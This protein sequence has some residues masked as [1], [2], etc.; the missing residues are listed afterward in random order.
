MGAHMTRQVHG[1]EGRQLQKAGIDPAMRSGVAARHS[2]DQVPLEPL[3][4]MFV[5]Q[6]IDLGGIDGGIH[7][8]RHQD[9][10][11]GRG[12]MVVFGHQRRSRQHGRA[13]LAYRHA[14]RARTDMPEKRD[15]VI[16]ILVGAEAAFGQRHVAAA[17]P[18]GDIDVVIGQQGLGGAPQQGGEMPRHRGRQQHSRLARSALLAKMY[19]VAERHFQGDLLGDG[20]AFALHRHLFDAVRRPVMDQV[21]AGDDLRPGRNAAKHVIGGRTQNGVAEGRLDQVGARTDGREQVLLGLI[22]VVQHP[23]SQ[24]PRNHKDSAPVAP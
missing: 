20:Q 12:G 21:G 10:A 16:D 24:A 11:F 6:D 7:R 9:Q 14:V 1:H 3:R 15:Q 19:Q 18:V 22:G 5:G 8:P 17:F 23:L 4:G 13:G 2:G